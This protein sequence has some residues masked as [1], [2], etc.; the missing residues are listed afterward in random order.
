LKFEGSKVE[1]TILQGRER[2]QSLNSAEAPPLRRRFPAHVGECAAM[3]VIW[4][5]V[6]LL[7]GALSRSFLSVG[8]LSVL[9]NS[10]PGLTVIAAG[11]T[12]VLIIGG[13]DLSVGS[14]MG[15]SGAGLGVLMADWNWP[16]WGAVLVCLGVGLAG[17][18]LNGVISVRLRIPSFIVTLGMLEIAR[19]LAYL[20]TNSQ[21]KYI[22]TAVESLA[23]PLWGLDVSSAFVIALLVVVAAQVA[24]SR[25]LFGRH[26]V[27]IGANEQAVRLA[28]INPE[29]A[30]I[31]VFALLG[32]LSGL[33]GVFYTS[34]LGSADPNAGVGLELSAIAAVVIGGTS[35]MGGRGSVVN[36]FFG[37][38]IIATLQAGL[39]QAGASEPVKRITTGA[40]I[41]IAVSLDAWRH[42]IAGCGFAPLRRLFASPGL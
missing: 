40:V 25:T 15:L 8:T 18:V 20:V 23:T 13:I 11:M 2:I 33:A 14:L 37:V 30:K 41:I 27:A 9:A 6:L 32:L 1:K 17:G 3:L 26:L 28:G 21:T 42:R 36:S 10:I 38:L 39:A 35:L 16:F 7:F 19:G 34:R 22:G 12:F 4:L 5:G 24:L 31:A 29:W